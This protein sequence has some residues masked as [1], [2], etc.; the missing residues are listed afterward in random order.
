MK[1]GK[2]HKPRAMGCGRYREKGSIQGRCQQSLKKEHI[3]WTLNE[4]GDYGRE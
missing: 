3:R 1:P 4:T 2:R